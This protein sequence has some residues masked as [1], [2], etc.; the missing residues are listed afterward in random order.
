[1]P[2]SSSFNAGD[3]RLF[4][5]SNPTFHFAAHDSPKIGE[6]HERTK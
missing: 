4:D 6:P 2:M 5:N 1:M 3:I